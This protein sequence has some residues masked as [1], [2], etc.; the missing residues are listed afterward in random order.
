MNDPSPR[1][2]RSA[3][4]LPETVQGVALGAQR[5]RV[6]AGL[7]GHEVSLRWVVHE[8]LGRVGGVQIMHGA[9]CPGRL[10]AT[11]FA[12]PITLKAVQS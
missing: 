3:L 11:V 10:D 5:E 9:C 7:V 8:Q 2:A 6:L 12:A 1:A 4:L